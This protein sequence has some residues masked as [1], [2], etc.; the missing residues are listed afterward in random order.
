MGTL[1]S[2]TN[3]A[4]SEKKEQTQETQTQITTTLWHHEVQTFY[5]NVQPWQNTNM[6]DWSRDQ[7]I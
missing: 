5:S 4:D 6:T 7:D 3:G 1:V 2:D